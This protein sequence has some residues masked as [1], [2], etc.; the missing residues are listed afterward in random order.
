MFNIK[1]ERHLKTMARQKRKLER[2]QGKNEVK[3]GG[4]T[5]NQRYMYRQSGTENSSTTSS[6]TNLELDLRLQ[7]VLQPQ[8]ASGIDG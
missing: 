1:E 8:A 7:P 2:L 6:I 3:T 5:N 4:R